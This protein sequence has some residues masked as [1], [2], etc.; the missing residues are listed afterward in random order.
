MTDL[1]KIRD[2]YKNFDEWGRLNT[3]PGQLE[4]KI[5]LSI[6]SNYISPPASIFDL[7][8]GAGRYTFELARMGYEMHLAD[9]SPHLINIARE[10]LADFGASERVKSISVANALDL[11]TTGDQEHENVLLFGPLYHLTDPA[12]IGKCLTEAYRILQPKGKILASFMPYHCGIISILERSFAS[13]DQVNSDVYSKVFQKGVFENATTSGFQEGN[14]LASSQLEDHF[15]NAGFEKLAL[16]SIRGIGYKH[17]KEIIE[18]KHKRP[19]YYR[20]IMDVLDQTAS[21]TPIIETCGH[22]IYVGEK[23]S[24]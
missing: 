10:K 16:R 15:K 1:D 3:C 20:T 2:Y 17:E 14:F 21:H 12:E 22:A 6:I 23:R 5:T 13:P 7:G 18:M 9:L 19:E 24:L 8:G 4:F 11:S